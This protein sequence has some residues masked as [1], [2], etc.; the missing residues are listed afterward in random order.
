VQIEAKKSIEMKILNEKSTR[1][2]LNYKLFM[3][4]TDLGLKTHQSPCDWASDSLDS[5]NYCQL[6][7]FSEETIER[8]KKEASSQ[9]K[10]S[11]NKKEIK[12]AI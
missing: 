12:L 11:K 5:I 7:F 9:K 8:L 10:S 1:Q 4:V 6:R 3:F 2:Q